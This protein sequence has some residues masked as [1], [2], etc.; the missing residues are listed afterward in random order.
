MFQSSAGAV[1]AQS[2]LV[3]GALPELSVVL[4]K[5]AGLFALALACSKLVFP[6][7]FAFAARSSELLL[8]VAL[9]ICLAFS[10]LA[11]LAGFSIAIGALL[12]GVAIAALPYNLEIG[13]KILSLRDF[14]VTIFFAA[15]G[16]QV[17]FSPQVLYSGLL[18]A[19]FVI[20]SRLAIV[21]PLFY[22]WRFGPGFQSSPPRP[23][24]SQANF[25]L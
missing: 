24:R 2:G 25:R 1:V 21:A 8:L 12:A 22:K 9:S 23:S 18:L 15:L 17:A 11:F 16:M 7:L 13:G 20:A 10:Y 19:A 4:V 3:A 6:P 5:G 14:F